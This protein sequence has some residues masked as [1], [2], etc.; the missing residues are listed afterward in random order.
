MILRTLYS[1]KVSQF[2]NISKLQLC[3]VIREV[4]RITTN[5]CIPRTTSG[6]WPR[7][8]RKVQYHKLLR[9]NISFKH[10]RNLVNSS[11]LKNPILFHQSFV[12]LGNVLDYEIKLRGA[13]CLVIW[14]SA[15]DY[16]LKFQGAPCLVIRVSAPDY[17]MKYGSFCN[18]TKTFSLFIVCLNS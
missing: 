7:S 1:P 14:G 10:F 13:Q 11:M 9:L 4:P 12:L 18:L 16:K 5:K 3:S 6:Q 17:E 15:P 8:R 2:E